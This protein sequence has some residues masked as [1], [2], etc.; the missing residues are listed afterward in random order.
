MYIVYIC[1]DLEEKFNNVKFIVMQ[2]I[3]RAEE[4]QHEQLV[5]PTHKNTQKKKKTKSLNSR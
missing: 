4:D 3:K 5:R 1:K 2:M